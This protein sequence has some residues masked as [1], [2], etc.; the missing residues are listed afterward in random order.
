MSLRLVVSVFEP[1]GVFFAPHV[2]WC[3]SSLQRA[4]NRPPGW[5]FSGDVACHRRNPVTAPGEFGGF[6]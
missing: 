4:L 6:S 3:G 1:H 2:N 5:R